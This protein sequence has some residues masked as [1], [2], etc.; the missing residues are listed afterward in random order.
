MFQLRKTYSVTEFVPDVL[1]F[2][3]PKHVSILKEI[4]KDFNLVCDFQALANPSQGEHLLLIGNQ[5]VGKN[6]LVDKFLQMLRIERE[7]IQLHRDTTV[8]SLTLIPVVHEGHIY[9]ED[10][11]LIRAGEPRVFMC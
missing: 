8:L 1:F 3:M 5:G 4:M 11:P 2:D 9:W 10:S 7:Y 6:K